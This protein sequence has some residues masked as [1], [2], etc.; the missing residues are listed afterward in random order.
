MSFTVVPL[1]NLDLPEGSRIPFGPKFTI[2]DIPEWIKKD[3]T[4]LNN[5][6]RHDRL[7]VLEDKQ[8]L[9]SEYV[10][11][12]YGYAD[13]DWK[14]VNPKGIQELRYQSA[15]LANIAI[16][17]I[18]PSPLCF[19]TVFHALTR[20]EGR[21]LE[22]PV[23]NWT[24]RSGAFYCHPNEQQNNV[25]WR[26]LVKAAKL[27]EVLD[28]VPRNNAVWSSIRAFSAALASFYADYRYPL[29]W[30]GL[31]SLFGSDTD[32]DKVSERLRNRI[33]RFISADRKGRKDINRMVKRCYKMRCE[34]VHG[35]WENEPTINIRMSET[36]SIVRTVLISLARDPGMLTSFMSPKRNSFLEAWEKE[37]SFAT[38][39]FP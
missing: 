25:T 11:D 31:E 7:S 20:L 28:T 24:D 8:A 6:A 15:F 16:W 4:T 22:T 34:I 14:G 27:F 18:Q 10:A 39:P 23:I 13:P 36:E 12:Y 19:T 9:V 21:E 1:H 33:S 32:R 29:F 38:P 26:E 3:T 35:R 5:L 17:L 37:R 30:Q 2:E